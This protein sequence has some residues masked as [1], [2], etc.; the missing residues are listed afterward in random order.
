VPVEGIALA[1]GPVRWIADNA[2]KGVSATA[3]GAVTVHLSPTFAAEHYSKTEAELAALVVPGIESLL[4]APVVNAALQRW[5]YS[6]PAATFAQ[7]CV[8][9]PEMGLGLAGDAFGGPR[10]EGAALSGLALAERMAV[11]AGA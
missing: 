9:L 10:V 2:K 1:D 11:S 7:P 4:G 6:E 3:A 5:K 8:W